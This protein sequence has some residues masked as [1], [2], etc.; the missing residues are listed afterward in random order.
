VTGYGLNDRGSIPSTGTDFSIRHD[1]G[2]TKWT[3]RALPREERGRI[4]K[5]TIVFHN[6]DA[7][8]E[9]NCASTPPY[10]FFWRCALLSTDV[11]LYFTLLILWGPKMRHAKFVPVSVKCRFNS[12]VGCVCRQF[13]IRFEG[14][15]TL[16]S[17]VHFEVLKN[18]PVLYFGISD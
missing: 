15:F 12:I 3:A 17:T 10:A 2:L 5:L 9:R 18:H 7:K 6:N 4:V 1:I 8:N 14:N 13:I 11:I 16:L